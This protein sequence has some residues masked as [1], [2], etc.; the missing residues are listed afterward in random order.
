MS[1][2]FG[3][4]I[5]KNLVG[6]VLAKH[7]RPHC[8]AGPSWC[9]DDEAGDLAVVE[10]TT[11]VGGPREPAGDRVP[12]KPFDPRDRESADTLDSERDD[13]VER[14]SPMLKPIVRRTLGRGER[15]SARDAPVSTALPGSRS[16]EAVVDDD[17][18]TDASMD[19]TYRR[20]GTSAML[21]FG[22]ALVDGRTTTLEIGLK[23]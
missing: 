21:H 5:D 12:G 14:R 7:Y 13:P 1:R 22:L 17:P 23:R 6:R 10:S 20:V 9:L 4:D 18:G 16:V 15:L 2:T 3:V 19:R 11:H 8:G